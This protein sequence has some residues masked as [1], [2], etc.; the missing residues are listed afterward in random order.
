MTRQYVFGQ[1]KKNLTLGRI[2]GVVTLLVVLVFAAL[3]VR[4]RFS[5]VSVPLQS[6]ATAATPPW[7]EIKAALAADDLPKAKTALAQYEKQRLSQYDAAERELCRIILA[8]KEGRSTEALALA[9]KAVNAYAATPTFPVLQGEYARLLESQGRHEEALALYKALCEQAPSEFQAVGFLGLGR[10]AD[11]EG[12]LLQAQT[13]FQEAVRRAAW[14]SEVWNEA[15]DALGR[16]NVALIFSPLQTPES[17]IYV[18][19]RGDT[20]TNIGIKLNTT[21]GL[22]LRA[23]NLKEGEALRP[24][25]KL[26]YTPKDFRIIIERST[27]R[28]FLV[29]KSGIFKRYRVGLGMP[30]F[31]TTLG[32]YVIGNKQKDPTWFK[33]G[34]KPIPPGD[35]T[36]ELGTR[37]MP[38]VPIE[39][40]LPTDLGIHG[41]IA[42][43][44]IGQYKS[45][46][47]PRM[48]KEDVEEL[49]DL[50]VR[51]TPVD[52]VETVEPNMLVPAEN[53]VATEAPRS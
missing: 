49:Y 4:A 36:N 8:R 51:A 9:E 31:E 40:G 27:C 16:V 38:L 28:L 53:R 43:E 34:S 12:D 44:T 23:N 26:K 6:E 14:D 2:L 52:I 25:Q 50:V 35:P 39:E 45:H 22:L 41:T 13:H 1:A 5:S 32:R 33:P 48:L 11:R 37:W 21:Q 30:G 20:L 46:G 42:P 24:G 7:A 18:V 29:D 19:Q 15:L 3:A 47:C 17:R 10:R